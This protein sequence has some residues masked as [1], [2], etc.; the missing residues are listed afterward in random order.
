MKQP[1]GFVVEGK[2]HLVCKLKHSLYGLKQSPRCW[3]YVHLKSMGFVQSANDPCI[4]T[5]SEGVYVDDI[6]IAGESS[7]RITEVKKALSEKFDVKDLGEL[8]Y[9]LG[10]Q[11]IQDHTDGKVW[12]GQSTFTE[13]VLRKYGMEE[14]K[15][16]KTPVNVNSK[17][18]KASEESESA[19]Q[20]LYQS[21]V[22]SLLY[23]S[24][25]TRPDIV[26]S[27]ACFCSNPT[28]EHWTAVKR[29]FRY[30]RGTTQFGLLHVLYA[31]GE[32][33]DLI[34]YSDADWAGDCNVYKSTTGYMFQI[35]GTAVT[36]KSNPVLC[37]SIHGRSGSC[38]YSSR[39]HL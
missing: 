31:K 27:A 21:A 15:S 38:E 23:L 11:V 29:I 28:K 9:F 6:V 33:S 30:L 32:S 14:A 8:N 4:Y 37:C 36:W 39:S 34:G 26:N 20:G 22:G 1:E 7:E 2:E 24:S 13:S 16:I 17:L 25:R 10:V 19:D 12:I 35:G 18:V 5:A 3:N